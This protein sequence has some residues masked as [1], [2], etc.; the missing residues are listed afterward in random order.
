MSVRA[1]L[2]FNL[3]HALIEWIFSNESDSCLYIQNEILSSITGH[4]F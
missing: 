3:D 1:K 2:K 4:S